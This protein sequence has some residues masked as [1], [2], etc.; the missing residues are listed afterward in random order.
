MTTA[1]LSRPADARPAD[2]GAP[3]R[4][5]VVR[6]AWRLFR[7]EW[8]QQ[9]LIL[10]LIT[11]AVAATIVGSAVATNNPPPKNSGFGTAQDSASFTTYD[12]HTASLIASLEHR[13]R[14]RRGDR[15]RDPV[16]P[17]IDQHL[18]GPGPRSRTDLSAVRCSRSSPGATRSGA[19]QVAVTSG[20]ASAFHVRVGAT[21]RSRRRRAPGGRHRGE[22]AEPPRRVR[23]RRARAGEKPH[24]ESRCLFD[25]PGVPLRSFKGY[26]V[27][28][29]PRSRSRT[30]STPRRSRWLPSSSACCSSPSSRSGASPCSPS[31][32][33]AR[34]ACSSRPGR[35]TATSVSSSAPT[36]RSSVS[37]GRS[38]AS[39]SGSWPGSPTARDSNR[40][41]TTSSECSPSRGPWSPPPWCSRSSPPTSPRP[42]RRGRSPRCRSSWRCR[43]GRRLLVRS[44]ARL[45]RHR[46]LVLA[47]L[48]LGYSGGTNHGSGSGGAPELLFGIVLLIPGL[49]LLAPFF[50]SFDARSP[51]VRRSRPARAARSRPVP[52]PLGL[53]AAAISL[54]VLIAVIVCS[55]PRPATGTSSTTRVRTSPRTSSAISA[56][57][58]APGKVRSPERSAGPKARTPAEVREPRSAGRQRRAHRE[59][60]RRAARSPRVECGN[61]HDQHPLEQRESG[62]TKLERT[63]LRRDAAAAAGVRDHAIRDRS[64][65]RTS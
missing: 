17:G 22:P 24:R 43:A 55:P 32:V 11:V 1:V 36:A 6:W 62:G 28:T 23:P 2:G 26:Q 49:I 35:R 45:S 16:D 34:S 14:P 41:R 25:A 3:A 65:T 40:A 42:G 27:Q 57:T 54:G 58:A 46:L 8:R 33:S 53:G 47:F 48:L 5:A 50:L 21:W 19:D 52:G 10:A 12:A 29:P 61:H 56:N 59:V 15:E 60:T 7:R 20:V 64:R 38:S 44:T 37:S 39:P 63:D 31:G 51:V 9:F 4:R 13:V 18:F 30:R